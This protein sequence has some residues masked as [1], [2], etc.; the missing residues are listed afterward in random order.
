MLGLSPGEVALIMAAAFAVFGPKD[1][2]II[3]RAAG[4]LAG[5]AVGYVQSARGSL[6]GVM[7]RAQVQEVHKEL[8]ETMAQL[9]AIRHEINSGISLVNPGP[10]TRRILNVDAPGAKPVSSHIKTEAEEM[11]ASHVHT[12]QSIIGQN[13][14][15]QIASQMQSLQHA[16]SATRSSSDTLDAIP[17]STTRAAVPWIRVKPV[18]EPAQPTQQGLHPRESL[19]DITV[20][21]ISAL[22]AGLLPARTEPLPGGSDLVYETIVERKVAFD[23]AEFFKQAQLP[24]E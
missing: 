22:S 19:K 21:P 7:Q 12:K 14:G 2:P 17:P 1:I 16:A 5:K 9:E 23:T 3:A 6:D 15:T 4:R 18:A 24:K 8:Q 20:L 11:S 13:L 10:M